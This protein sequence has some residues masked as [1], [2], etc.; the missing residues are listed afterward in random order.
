MRGILNFL[1]ILPLFVLF[2]TNIFSQ[3]P[4]SLDTGREAAI[5]GGGIILS[6]VDL[7]IISNTEPIP[8]EE[9]RTLSRNNINSFDRGATYN[10]SPQAADW[11]DILLITSVVSPLLSFT[12]SAVQNDGG[13]YITMYLQNILT[14][15]SI[16][17]LP[18][19]LVRRYRPYSYNTEVDD[20]IRTRQ[21]ATLSFFSAHTSVSFASAVFLSTTFNKYNPDSN[22]TPYIWGT[23]LLLASAVGYLRFASGDHFP[24]DIIVGAIVG[25]VIG[26]LIPLIHESDEDEKEFFGPAGN[27][28]NNLISF[29]INF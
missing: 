8:I 13:T 27:P 10:W 24:T 11:S 23:S 22:L 2:Q 26:Y 7:K 25:S 18:K 12:S 15:Y 5:F 20:S 3:S 14:I 21:G 17:H 28:Y 9:L 1:Y 19:P 6:A 4:Y 16:S 29:N